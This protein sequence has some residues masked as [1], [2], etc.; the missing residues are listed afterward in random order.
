MQIEVPEFLL[1]TALLVCGA[2]I[3]RWFRRR[4]D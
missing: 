2:F 3:V 1:L 4:S